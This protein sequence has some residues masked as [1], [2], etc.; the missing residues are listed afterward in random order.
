MAQLIRIYL[1]I[2]F[3][4][5]MSTGV[6]GPYVITLVLWQLAE[7]NSEISHLWAYVSGFISFTISCHLLFHTLVGIIFTVNRDISF[8]GKKDNIL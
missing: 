1:W 7:K 8:I 5:M 6:F 4:V 2:C 3:I